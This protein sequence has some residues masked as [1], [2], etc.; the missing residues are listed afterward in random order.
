MF[1]KRTQPRML[2]PTMTCS[3]V[4]ARHA[5]SRGRRTC[6]A[7]GGRS[8]SWPDSSIACT[9]WGITGGGVGVDAHAGADLLAVLD[10][11]R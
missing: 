10:R 5:R 11:S 7:R 9:H 6:C 8:C 2:I 3:A 1:L 4:Q